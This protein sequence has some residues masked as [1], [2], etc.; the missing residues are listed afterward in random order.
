MFHRPLS[1]EINECARTTETTVSLVFIYG[2]ITRKST[3]NEV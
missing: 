2:I 3:F 1:Y